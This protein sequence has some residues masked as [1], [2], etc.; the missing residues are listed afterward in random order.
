MRNR[1]SRKKTLGPAGV[2]ALS[3]L[4]F[5]LVPCT[6]HPVDTFQDFAFVMGH[7]LPDLLLNQ[8]QYYL[9]GLLPY[10]WSVAIT[11]IL[12]PL[13]G[14]AVTQTLLSVLYSAIIL[15]FVFTFVSAGLWT[16]LLLSLVLIC[17][18]LNPGAPLFGWKFPYTLGNTF[19]VV[20][21]C[22]Y[23][24]ASLRIAGK[25]NTRWFVVL[26][27]CG[28]MGI[29]TKTEFAFVILAYYVLWAILH[30]AWPA[31]PAR[32]TP[33][34]LPIIGAGGV[35]L[36]TASYLNY[37]KFIPPLLRLPGWC[38]DPVTY[39]V[40]GR[41]A[42]TR[43]ASG[44]GVM[45]NHA[46]QILGLMDFHSFRILDMVFQIALLAVI[47]LAPKAGFLSNR[48]RKFYAKA[49]FALYCA[50]IVLVV[51]VDPMMS[52]KNLAIITLALAALVGIR[53]VRNR[54]L[55]LLCAFSTL[56]IARTSL[57]VEFSFFSIYYMMP[58][59]VL[60]LALISTALRHN[61]LLFLYTL[62]LLFLTGLRFAP[63]PFIS[64]PLVTTVT[65]DA[66]ETF[67][68]PITL[69]ELL[70]SVDRI[71]ESNDVHSIGSAKNIPFLNVFYDVPN[72]VKPF[73]NV[74][75]YPVGFEECYEP[76]IDAL[77][78]NRPDVF[79]Y[80]EP[81]MCAYLTT[82]EHH[83][84]EDEEFR[85]RTARFKADLANMYDNVVTVRRPG[86]TTDGTLL[87]RYRAYY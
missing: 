54:P 48:R 53:V 15:T 39:T 44:A 40:L 64:A 16:R 69:H 72:P 60:F 41:E 24:L 31:S 34:S 33:T 6:V 63:H 58:L 5:H 62:V 26:I 14:F 52:L 74:E 87:P 86:E 45:S 85:D 59:V 68:V 30:R 46:R 70:L 17:L 84:L 73:V 7:T 57:N 79:V 66:G 36:A 13:T 3:Q 4:Y 25:P 20:A 76:Y 75:F 11:E 49:A 77:D 37:A 32:V 38:S 29:S 9:Y 78:V 43:S 82:E 19:G 2:V 28:V 27:V 81:I 42:A 67:R 35:L 50:H 71:R 83:G 10:L 47:V 23:F 65:S 55:L 22:G 80:A 56:C 8:Y 51:S 61:G 12:P 1:P 18:L 21:T